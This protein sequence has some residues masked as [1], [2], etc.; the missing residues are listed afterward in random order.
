MHTWASLLCEG[1][2]RDSLEWDLKYEFDGG[3]GVFMA[4][5]EYA[6]ARRTENDHLRP[7]L[8]VLEGRIDEA[9]DIMDRRVRQ[10]PDSISTMDDASDG[11][12]FA[13]RFPSRGESAVMRLEHRR[14][15]ISCGRAMPNSMHR[16]GGAMN[17]LLQ[18]P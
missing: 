6:E 13:R 4:V 17:I 12:Y 8:L 11:Y 10:R 18:Q 1:E 16:A 15:P 3:I 5:H 7:Y 9:V 2:L 14:L